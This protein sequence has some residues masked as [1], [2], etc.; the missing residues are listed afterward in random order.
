MN[1][2]MLDNHNRVVGPSHRVYFLGDARGRAY[3]LARRPG[4]RGS[5]LNGALWFTPGRGSPAGAADGA[6]PWHPVRVGAKPTHAG[7]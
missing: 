2:T 7:A 4:A 5:G 3:T 6:L 1:E